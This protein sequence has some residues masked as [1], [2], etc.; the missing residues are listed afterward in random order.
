MA[1]LKPV[2]HDDRLTV[3]EHLDELRTRIVVS[4][5][6]FGVALAL[7]F[8]QNHQLLHWLNKP[9]HGKQPITFGVAEAFTTTLTVTCYAALVLALPVVL[10]QLYAYVLP[11]FTTHELR[12]V[13]PLIIMVP[14]LFI[15]GALFGYFLVVP[16][17]TKFLLH[18]NADEFNTQI[19]AR[20][21]YY[22]VTT[23]MLACGVVF[24]M[25]V[26]ILAATR[27][28]LT[29]AEKLRKNRRYAILI[30]TIIGAALPGVDP[31]S[32]ILETIPLILLFE[33]S[34]LLA[35]A[36]APQPSEISERWASAEGS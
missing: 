9:L 36:F 33:L 13:R 28:G 10:Y 18:F 24:Q 22:F 17:A 25:P 15:S 14:V 16:A 8:W 1:R 27:L 4:L 20:D 32:M 30:C 35:K 19:R 31:V 34:I 23:T 5:A 2:S 29:S 26:V 7:C 11:A 12:V 6:A 21:Y 3:V